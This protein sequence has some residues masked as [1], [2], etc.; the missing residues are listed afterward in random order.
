MIC[1]DT[2]FLARH[3]YGLESRNNNFMTILLRQ[4]T[5]RHHQSVTYRSLL[6]KRGPAPR[7]PRSLFAIAVNCCVGYSITLIRPPPASQQ[8]KPDSMPR[9]RVNWRVGWRGKRNPSPLRKKVRMR[10]KRF[11]HPIPFPLSVNVQSTQRV[12]HTFF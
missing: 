2:F 8:T 3:F 11:E 4:A 10:T 6:W 1:G 5:K 9:T 12:S 7:Q